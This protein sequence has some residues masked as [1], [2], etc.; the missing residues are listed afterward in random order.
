MTPA[1]IEHLRARLYLF[2]VLPAMDDLLKASPEACSVLG[3]E[4]FSIAFKT[5]SGLRAAYFLYENHCRFVWGKATERADVELFF[6]SD[7]QANATFEGR[8]S[9]PPMPTRGFS[10][11]GKVKIFQEIAGILEDF[12][13]PSP[14]ALKDKDF[15]EA[16]VKTYFGIVLR[17]LCQLCEHEKKGR[18]LFKNGPQGLAQFQLGRDGVPTWLNLV[19][20]KLDWGRGEPPRPSDVCICFL[21]PEVA[22]RALND[23]IDAQVELGLGTLEIAGFSPLA[24]QVNLLLE[25]IELYLPKGV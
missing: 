12:L 8:K 3:S 7:A 11:I 19:S 18:E 22:I 1:A 21:N 13:K 25:R 23:Q 5:R 2:A 24:E 4:P 15:R 10:K 17:A 9:I 14:E 16:F 6:H 20:R